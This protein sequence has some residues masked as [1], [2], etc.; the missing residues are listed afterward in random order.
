MSLNSILDRSPPHDL[1]AERIVIGSLILDPRLVDD[2]SAV[3]RP[4]D[5]FDSGNRAVFGH[6]LDI[7]DKGAVVDLAILVDRLT[8]TDSLGVIG[9]IGGLSKIVEDTPIA[10]NAVYFA[11]SIRAKAVRREVVM[12]ATEAIRDAF[13]D[14]G[15][16]DDD[17]AG[18]AQQRLASVAD[19]RLSSSL[20]TIADVVN[21]SVK[22][23]DERVDDDN[24]GATGIATGFDELDAKLGGIRPGELVIIAARPGCGKTS[25]A[26]N[27]AEQVADQGEG[28]LFVSLEMSRVELGDRLLSSRSGVPLQVVR[29]GTRNEDN[30][31]A[32]EAARISLSKL[33]ITFDDSSSASMASIAASARSV[34]RSR[35]LALL[36][37]DYLTLIEPADRRAPQHEQVSGISRR[38]KTLARELQVPVVCLA[39]LNRDIERG[40]DHRPRLSHLRASGAIEQDADA[41]LFVH[42]EEL[43]RPDNDDLRGKAEIV[44]AKNRHGPTGDVLLTWQSQWTR[45]VSRA[46]TE[47][48]FDF[49]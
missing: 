10:S 38:L 13:R 26:L 17:V 27:V 6:M 21:A 35:G 46:K 40:G 44:I 45:F 2:V 1:N 19:R 20:A 24:Q 5:F 48:R 34:Q 16:E 3:V 11:K 9:G 41:V 39:Q 29:R 12:A 7:H 36:V 25:F 32:I 31:K 43:F 37:I 15:T 8:A 33:P 42:R 28:V 30:R 4:D 23:H 47:Q 49:Q 18:R 14:D 22:A